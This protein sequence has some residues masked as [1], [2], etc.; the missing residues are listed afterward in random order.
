[1]ES[2]KIVEADARREKRP[3]HVDMRPRMDDCKCAGARM[4]RV[5]RER[6]EFRCGIVACA[7]R[8][9]GSAEATGYNCSF[10]MFIRRPCHCA[11]FGVF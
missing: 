11:I 3:V 10:P 6:G 9:A 8:L 1:M 7:T 2:L 4:L 5:T